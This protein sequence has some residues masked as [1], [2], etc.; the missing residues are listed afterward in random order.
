MQL[1]K[2]GPA[3]F[4]S[5]LQTCSDVIGDARSDVLVL[6]SKCE[7]NLNTIAVNLHTGRSQG[8]EREQAGMACL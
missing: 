6:K 2:L 8:R 3:H 1:H 5:Y 7:D 4:A